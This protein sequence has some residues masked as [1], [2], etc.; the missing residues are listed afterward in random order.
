[1]TVCRNS[2]LVFLVFSSMALA[3]RSPILT[4]SLSSSYDLPFLERLLRDPIL[5]QPSKMTK[6]G[7]DGLVQ[8]IQ[9]VREEAG[10]EPTLA[11]LRSLFDDL[12]LY[13]Y[14]AGD[15][16]FGRMPPPAEGQQGHV[17]LYQSH[18]R[19]VDVGQKLLKYSPTE[20]ERLWVQIQLSLIQFQQVS[21]RA[22][23]L[24]KLKGL[25]KQVASNKRYQ[26]VLLVL[27]LAE[28]E[29]STTDD[30]VAKAQRQLRRLQI[31]LPREANTL[32]DLVMARVLSRKGESEKSRE[33]IQLVSTFC[34]SY[35]AP[36]R[37]GLLS[38]ILATWTKDKRFGGN[39]VRFP[40]KLDCFEDLEL[41]RAVTERIAIQKWRNDQVPTAVQ[42]YRYLIAT[43]KQKSRRQLLQLRVLDLL[44]YQLKSE[45]KVNSSASVVSEQYSSGWEQ[46][47]AEIEKLYQEPQSSLFARELRRRHHWFVD[48]EINQ[49]DLSSGVDLPRLTRVVNSFV[50]VKDDAAQ[51]MLVDLA[52]R[53]AAARR[54]DLAAYYYAEAAS[55]TKGQQQ[56]EYLQNATSVQ[57]RVAKW[58]LLEPHRSPEKVVPKERAALLAY[59]KLFPETM[60][61]GW[62]V[63]RHIARLTIDLGSAQDGFQL[64]MD[65]IAR[66]PK[67]TE[68]ARAAS[69]IMQFY[70]ARKDWE[71]LI[72]Y[73]D[74]LRKLGVEGLAPQDW[75]AYNQALAKIADA[76][77]K[78]GKDI[79]AIDKL[80]KLLDQNS[81]GS[82]QK[83]AN[84]IKLSQ[85]LC[86]VKRYVECRKLIYDLVDRPL[87]AATSEEI[88]TL[89]A[90]LSLGSG[91]R[92]AGR[93]YLTK[94]LQRF[95]DGSKRA[96][97]MLKL[98]H[99][100]EAAND[101]SGAWRALAEGV[102]KVEQPELRERLG[103]LEYRIWQ[104]LET[105]L[106]PVTAIEN[107]G[108]DPY[109]T[110]ATKARLCRIHGQYAQLQDDFGRLNEVFK[111]LQTLDSGDPAVREIA[112]ETAFLLVQR[113]T[114]KL[115]ASSYEKVAAAGNDKK[116]QVVGILDLV[117]SYHESP[118]QFGSFPSCAKS[119]D[120]LQ[121][122]IEAV[123]DQ[124]GQAL[125][126]VDRKEIKSSLSPRID[127]LREK[128]L[129]VDEGTSGRS[130]KAGVFDRERFVQ[131]PRHLL[132]RE[133][134][135]Q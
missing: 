40:F 106:Q 101:W 124:L 3:N 127:V 90:E 26:S 59:F 121:D 43:E 69:D 8:R 86:K 112:S 60:R 75:G 52:D 123:A 45:S 103:Q 84:Q 48:R 114:E 28:L 13:S 56:I 9:K 27:G 129:N 130:D 14:Y 81:I 87:P 23:A 42:Q 32:V 92:A 102:P 116:R 83:I 18:E 17:L 119:L 11:H 110:A 95:P 131:L 49:F 132:D 19:V 94:Y 88:L 37:E 63:G 85:L 113:Q 64:W 126:E 125:S 16:A 58:N 2:I 128:Y 115:V 10:S 118:C 4:L 7:Y 44:E 77:I 135:W 47:L 1:M 100:H 74:M 80:V 66:H 31:S 29:Q 15:I 30:Q 89:A 38:H 33:R 61:Q 107:I 122:V 41:M 68:A 70:A 21:T 34:G 53:F 105:K 67:G 54:H 12:L 72:V 134:S 96:W 46:Y 98:V 6:A 36:E 35:T 109:L 117:L 25:E 93:S 104:R 82:N 50:S 76:N 79:A 5:Y 99:L 97:A 73:G 51:K 22:E 78:Q 62:P 24:E 71:Q 57:A 91:D 55:R 111:Q 133:R 39:W 120:H 65:L 108:P 20:S